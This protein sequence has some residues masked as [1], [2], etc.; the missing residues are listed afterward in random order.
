MKE[1]ENEIEQ[2]SSDPVPPFWIRPEDHRGQPVDSRVLDVSHRL[3]PWAYRHVERELRDGARAAELL[4]QVAMD[5]SSRVHLE[6]A[7][8]RNLKGYLITAFHYRVRWERLKNSRLLYEGLLPDLDA[9]YRLSVP[10][11]AAAIE[12][13]LVLRFLI[14]CLPHELRHMLHYRMLEF[15]WKRI[16][17]FMGISAKQAKSRFYYGVQ[18]AYEAL[19]DDQAKRANREERG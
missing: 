6:P 8:A 19:L 17:G 3:W 14:S 4:E 1:P 2:Q 12:S 9:K 5:V 13:E 15:S 11:W 7:V 10:D 18:K 16:G